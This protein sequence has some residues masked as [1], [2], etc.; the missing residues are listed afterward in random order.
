MA[1]SL[2]KIVGMFVEIAG[3]VMIAVQQ[4]FRPFMIVLDS[5]VGKSDD[6]TESVG[7]LGRIFALLGAILLTP[8]AIL[9]QINNALE[10]LDGWSKALAGGTLVYAVSRMSNALLMFLGVGKGIAGFVSGFSLVSKVLSAVGVAIKTIT[11]LWAI[12]PMG[13]LAKIA[14]LAVAGVGAAY[15]Y[16]S[17]DDD[18]DSAKKAASNAVA[19]NAKASGG[20]FTRAGDTKINNVTIQSHDTERVGVLVKDILQEETDAMFASSMTGG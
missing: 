6:A 11:F 20:G 13:R 17:G 9:E 4:I 14:S 8:F 10:G 5:L 3:V 19:S 7:G 16:F 12:S 15:A 1:K 2:G 18:E